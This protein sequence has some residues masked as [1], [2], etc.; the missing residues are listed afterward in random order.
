LGFAGDLDK[1]KIGLRIKIILTGI[2]N[3]P[4]IAIFFSLGIGKDLINFTLLQVFTIPI[5]YSEGYF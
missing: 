4:E 1:D 2:V 3:H 5:L